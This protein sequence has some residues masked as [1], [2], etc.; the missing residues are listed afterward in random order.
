MAVWELYI[1]EKDKEKLQGLLNELEELMDFNPYKGG[2]VSDM[3]KGGS[4]DLTYPERIVS[5]K[6][7]LEKRIRETAARMSDHKRRIE[8]YADQMPEP[9]RT[10]ILC[11]A[12]EGMSWADISDKVHLSRRT[13]ARRFSGAGSGFSLA[14]TAKV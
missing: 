3:P 12:V 11:R 2:E 4:G 10:I 5:H 7:R 13:V 1:I 14:P 8:A 9:D 6:M